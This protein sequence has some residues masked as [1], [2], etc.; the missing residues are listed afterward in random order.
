MTLLETIRAIEQVAAA[1]PAVKMAVRNDI[2]RLNACPEARYGVFG[3]TQLDHSGNVADDLASY[4]FTLFYVDR[5]TADGGN[6]TE[7]QSV[8]ISVLDNIVRTL[9]DAGIW[10]DS[11]TFNV[12]TQRFVDECAGAFTRVTFTVPLDGICADGF[13]DFND[14]F[15]DDFLIF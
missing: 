3:W 10:A 2:Y 4:S 13:G 8:G 1:Q 12:F 6:E 7:V 11:W 5:L 9:N 14:D 15:N